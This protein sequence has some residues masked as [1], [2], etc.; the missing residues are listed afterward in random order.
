MFMMRDG[1]PK[2]RVRIL[3]LHDTYIQSVQANF[4]KNAVHGATFQLKF[5]HLK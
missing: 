3:Y 2:V 5:S 4:G 1:H